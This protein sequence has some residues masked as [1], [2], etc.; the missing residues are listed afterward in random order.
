MP[1][2][3]LYLALEYTPL[4]NITFIPTKGIYFFS[5]IIIANSLLQNIDNSITE[6]NGTEITQG[7]KILLTFTTL[8]LV[9][10]TFSDTFSWVYDMC[11]TTQGLLSYVKPC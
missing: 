9:I 1:A 3:P 4:K 5:F 6:I 10:I 8:F 11:Y 2:S 7:I